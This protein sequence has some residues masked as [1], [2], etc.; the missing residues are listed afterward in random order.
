MGNEKLIKKVPE[1]KIKRMYTEK[2]ER[3]REEAD[4]GEDEAWG[5][6]MLPKGNKSEVDSVKTLSDDK[7]Y[8]ESL[9]S[10]EQLE[11]T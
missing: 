4:N 3:E 7:L 6:D 9:K 11:N 1:S 2:L 10:N 5:A 8:T